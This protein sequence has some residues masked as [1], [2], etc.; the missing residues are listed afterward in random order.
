MTKTEREN[1]DCRKKWHAAAGSS[2]KVHA[3]LN[4]F[5]EERET[6]LQLHL[7]DE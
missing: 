7:N 2:F 6:E 4:I 3:V 5:P 1:T